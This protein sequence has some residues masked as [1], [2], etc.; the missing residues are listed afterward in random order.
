MANEYVDQAFEEQ[1]QFALDHNEDFVYEGHFTEEYSRNLIRIFKKKNYKVNMIFMG[2]ES[3]KISL[4]RVLNR[5]VKGGHNVPP[6]EVENNYY[7]NLYKLNEHFKLLD[8]LIILDSSKALVT[9]IG[10]WKEGQMKFNLSD[11][12]MPEW[13]I[14]YLPDLYKKK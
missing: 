2:L 1:Y 10:V 13:V 11:E 5:A 14:K 6:Y 8:E 7:G 4:D 12:E 3:V 9:Q